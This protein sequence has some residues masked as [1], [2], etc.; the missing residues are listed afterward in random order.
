MPK[1]PT[2]LRPLALTLLLAAVGASGLLGGC[3]AGPATP[4]PM[5]TE[6]GNAP[7]IAQAR[8]RADQTLPRPLPEEVHADRHH[9]AAVLTI[10]S[11]RENS[12]LPGAWHADAPDSGHQ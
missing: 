5:G 11:S 1:T 12:R 6:T 8:A 2:C 3:V 10:S 7:Q 4:V 9:R